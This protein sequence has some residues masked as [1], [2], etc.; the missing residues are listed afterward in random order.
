MPSRATPRRSSAAARRERGPSWRPATAWA[1]SLV[2]ALL[3]LASGV[4]PAPL[5]A[6]AALQKPFDK[7]FSTQDNGAISIIGNAQL[8]CPATAAGCTSARTGGGTG[9][10][11]NNNNYTMSF[12][13][14]DDVASTTNSSSAE[15]AL[16]SGSKVLYA[17]LVWSARL[18]VGGNGAAGTG[19]LGAAKFRAPNQ[20]GYAAVTA[21]SVTQTTIDTTPYQASLDVTSTVRDGG[22]G[23]YF[24]ADMVAATGSD[25][26]AGWSLA[27]VYANPSLPLRDL[28]VFDGF[29]DISTATT[30]NS[31]VSTTVSGFITPTTGTVN[32]T[33]GVA[34]WE[35]DL[36]TTGDVL[37]FGGTTL[38]DA[39]RP[40]NNS[41]DSAISTF[42][43]AQAAKNPTYSNNFGVD[44]GRVSANGVLANGA[45][46]ATVN[47][48]TTGDTIYLGMLTT[49]D[50]PLHAV[51]R[52]HQ[53]DRHRPQRQ[54]PR[55]RSATPSST[56]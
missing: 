8:S 36:G 47:V 13:D 1:L 20:S 11:L 28:T 46:S 18:V 15:L 9:T 41:F 43:I 56:G 42:G 22:N 37:K 29:A 3:V 39:A 49:G 34:A 4:L 5:P 6:E 50:R 54:Q 7:V 23:T 45:T 17:R 31:S 38:A 27:V 40:A 48:S 35:G 2:L 33:V 14:V 26:Y 53:Q 30:A 44:M 51:L 55:A 21:T 10:A 32:A 12:V 24:F 52:R 25:R 16:P 19:T